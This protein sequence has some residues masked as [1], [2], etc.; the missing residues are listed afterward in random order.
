MF[1]LKSCSG[2]FI[3]KL[4]ECLAS[5]ELPWDQISNLRKENSSLL[6]TQEH[7]DSSLTRFIEISSK[8]QSSHMHGPSPSSKGFLV[9]LRTKIS[10]TDWNNVNIHM[11]SNQ[12]TPAACIN[13]MKYILFWVFRLFNH[14]FELNCLLWNNDDR[15]SSSLQWTLN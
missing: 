14:S 13:T 12:L 2:W 3:A 8:V 9:E 11:N 4:F 6:L 15:P 5:G 10:V 7:A 1:S